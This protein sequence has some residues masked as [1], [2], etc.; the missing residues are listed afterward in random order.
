MTNSMIPIDPSRSK[1]SLPVIIGGLF[2]TSLTLLGVW[3][4]AQA[5]DNLNIMGFYTHGIIP[6]GAILVG[7]AAGSGYGLASWRTGIRISKNLL[8]TVLAIQLL[9]YF[10]AQYLEYLH[11][12]KSQGIDP[13]ELGFLTFFDFTTRS[14]SFQ[15]SDGSARSA[16]GAWG[17]LF[18]FLEIAGFVLGAIVAPLALMKKPYCDQ[19]Q[20]YMRTRSL[21]VI[22]AG[23]KPQKIKKKNMEALEE[24]NKQD[25]EKWQ[26]GLKILEDIRKSATSGKT[27]Q[28]KELIERNHGNNKE[29]NKLTH[30]I[31]VSLSSCPSCHTAHLNA[32]S[33]SGQGDRIVRENL[34]DS[35]VNPGLSREIKAQ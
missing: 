12:I 3:A 13:Q 24:F 25:Q 5:S 2:T 17:Y 15:D 20:L 10:V 18:R 14:F 7:L 11:I 19:C 34:G 8:L 29:K 35:P 6:V 33:L 26:G 1:S 31:A 23:I 32:Q 9:A 28:F 21:G 16:M 4:L 30:R 22:P 27:S